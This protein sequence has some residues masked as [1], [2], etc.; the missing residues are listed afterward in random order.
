MRRAELQD[1][2]AINRSSYCS[3]LF[4]MLFALL[5]FFG[6]SLARYETSRTVIIN[7][8]TGV[9]WLERQGRYS[10]LSVEGALP[11]WSSSVRFTTLRSIPT[12]GT[13]VLSIPADAVA[14]QGEISSGELRVDLD[15]GK[16]TVHL[17]PSD[18]YQWLKMDG[19]YPVNKYIE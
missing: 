13:F 18:A 8:T 2:P 11:E 19:T 15:E 16:A 17:K 3:V 7:R 14:Q 1:S 5:T 10:G 4:L 9:I 12:N 6:C